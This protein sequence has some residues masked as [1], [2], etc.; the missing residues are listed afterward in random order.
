MKK[1]LVIL[2]LLLFI[3]GNAQQKSS[4]KFGKIT[5]EDFNVIP[6][7]SDSDANAI[8]IADIGESN[9]RTN[10]QSVLSLKYNRF[11]R[12]KL[13][14]S[15]GFDAATITIPL[16]KGDHSTEKLEDFK[17]FTY[18]LVNGK[19]EETKVN[20]STMIVEN[21]NKNW[22]FKKITFPNISPGS[23]IEYNYTINSDFFTNIQPWTFQGNYP[24]L[25]SEYNVEI[26]EFYNYIVVSQGY[27]PFHIKE[28]SSYGTILNFVQRLEDLAR[29][30]GESQPSNRISIQAD[31]QKYK[32][33]MKN[34]PSLKEEAFTTTV[35]N[36]IAK[37][38]FQLNTIKYPNS[39]IQ[40]VMNNWNKV[41]FELNNDDEFGAS[42][43]KNNYWIEDL[44]PFAIDTT[45]PKILIAKKLY[46]FV[47]NNFTKKYDNS[48]YLHASLKDIFK[49]KTGSSSEINLLLTALLNHYKVNTQPIILSTRTHGKVHEFYPLLSRYNH[50]ITQVNLEN[51]QTIYLDASVP[52]LM[53]GRLPLDCFNGQARLLTKD[54]LV[55]L[56]FSPETLSENSYTNVFINE[57]D[58]LE[59]TISRK[60][61]FYQSKV[62]R[63]QLNHTDTKKQMNYF[64][65]KINPDF[66][67]DSL[68]IDSL[69]TI[70]ESINIDLYTSFNKFTSDI[71]YFNPFLVSFVEK[72][73]F[74][75]T[76]RLYPVEMPYL[77]NDVFTL[78]MEVPKGYAIEELP[79]SIRYNYNENEGKFEYILVN[80]NGFIQFKS[81]LS[82]N[83]A[84]FTRDDYNSL[85][86]FF[87]LI[88]AKQNEKIVF[89]KIKS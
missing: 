76:N 30:Y 2:L 64:A 72:N 77:S 41:A 23:I 66:S 75:S 47:R 46:E 43:Y 70:N 12:I 39:N 24:C 48:F 69:N 42:L 3:Q 1:I 56:N 29:T 6:P 4:V 84:N 40:Y 58:K 38:E 67:I 32:W 88:I 60:L 80:N 82:L 61:G 18:N 71:V 44:L 28:E 78:S 13:V 36:H 63:E 10:P 87:S 31:I 53:F 11:S 89:K 15:N 62:I 33:V 85:R 20:S 79:K 14:N 74:K 7:A 54:D 52:N 8:I 9:F 16:Y 22:V 5:K 34:V 49:N 73:P 19:V 59:A 65:T 27:Q 86:D 25:W 83:K 68:L 26:P 57:G 51:D 21:Y 81:V 55:P 50:V 35:N 45:M 17:A 37:I